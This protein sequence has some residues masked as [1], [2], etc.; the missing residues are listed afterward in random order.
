MSKHAEGPREPTDC[1]LGEV[2]MPLPKVE[3]RKDLV[4]VPASE[5]NEYEGGSIINRMVRKISARR[6]DPA[7]LH[8]SRHHG[9]VMVGDAKF[10]KVKKSCLQRIRSGRRGGQ[11]TGRLWRPQP[12]QA[13]HHIAQ[14]QRRRQRFDLNLCK[15]V[16]KKL[17][18]IYEQREELS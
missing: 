5:M 3:I 4:P 1:R 17:L 10:S 7:R 11:P 6:S 12:A 18:T 9:R 2:H 16:N 15:S 13:T 14:A 8:S